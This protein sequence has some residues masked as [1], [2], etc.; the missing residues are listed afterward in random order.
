MANVK[1]SQLPLATSPLDSAV[2][3][4]VVQGGVTK[5]A[6]MTTIGFLQSGT[7]ATLRTAQNKMRDTVSVKDF[8]AVGDGVTNDTAAIQAAIL[9]GAGR[10]VYFPG[11][12][13]LISSTLTIASTATRLYGDGPFASRI[14]M[15]TNNIGIIAFTGQHCRF[16]NFSVNYTTTPIS[17]ATA[18]RIESAYIGGNDFMVRSGWIGILIQNAAQV[19]LSKFTVLNTEASAVFLNGGVFDAFFDQFYINCGNKL[20]GQTGNIRIVNQ[21]EAV[22][23]TDGEVLEGRFGLVTD[24]TVNTNGNRPAYMKFNSVFF[25]SSDFG[26][27][28]KNAALVV[29]TACWWSN[30]RS[31]LAG[32]QL[33]G[34]DQPACTITGAIDSFT[35]NGCHFVSGGSHGVFLGSAP[36]RTTF[37]G[38][39]FNS[40][41]AG[42]NPAD[43]YGFLAGAGATDFTITGSIATNGLGAGT[44]QYGIVIGSGASDRYVITDNQLTGNSVGSLFDGGTGTNKR[45][46]DNIGYNPTPDT[47]I[48]VTASP[49]TWTNNTGAPVNV[50]I[51]G[52]TVSLVTN[53]GRA[54]GVAT[55]FC[56]VVAPG[57]SVVITYTVAPTVSRRGVT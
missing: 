6:G 54:A 4:P 9:A 41:H 15:Q 12:S 55:N 24:A 20:R 25:D 39:N 19:Y 35:F 57:G 36:A 51:G 14:E 52:G 29:F 37:I 38:C 13:Y 46:V 26:T 22:V 43:A 47:V 5:R 49:F 30:G 50:A 32:S 33:A 7:S 17:G 11:G 44:Q 3:M 10:S 45:V 40:N 16:D 53:D 31:D 27:D 34:V 1:I 2:E 8:G 21:C 56:T 28:L 48:T 42:P 23:F 18:I